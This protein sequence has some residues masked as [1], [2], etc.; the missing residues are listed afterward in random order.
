MSNLNW[1]TFLMKSEPS[2]PSKPK[3]HLWTVDESK[4]LS[5]DEVKILKK[6]SK[7]LLKIGLEKRRFSLVRDW[8]MVE[9]GL[10]SG[11]RVQEMA[12]LMH[13]NLFINGDRSSVSVIG[14]GKKKRSVWIGQDFKEKCFLYRRCKIEFGYSVEA[15][16][17][18][19]NN[20]QGRQISKR[21]LQKF[22]TRIVIE[23]GLP[24]RYSIHNL[25]HTYSTF[26][27]KASNHNYRFVQSQLGHSSIRTT[28]VYAGIVESDARQAI[29]NMYSWIPV[30]KG[31]DINSVS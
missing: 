2:T 26:L 20:L 27:L 23:A 14:K 19:L 9:L 6:Y 18:L 12:S 29:N 1:F 30:K 22:F 31:G 17:F 21:A 4:C 15:D 13:Q 16:S 3:R 24:S 5:E 10:N 25:R 8:F 11:L 7:Q 28:Q